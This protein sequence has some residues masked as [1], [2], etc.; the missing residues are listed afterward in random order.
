MTVKVP[1]APTHIMSPGG[2]FGETS[3][4]GLSG[5]NTESL[6]IFR[7]YHAPCTLITQKT[8]NRATHTALSIGN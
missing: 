1:M 2:V 8:K 3:R 5:Y 4:L 6:T 7:E